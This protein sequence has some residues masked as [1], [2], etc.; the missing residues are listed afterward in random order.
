MKKL[1]LVEITVDDLQ[2]LIIDCVVTC[3]KHHQPQP[4][5]NTVIESGIKK[6][7]AKKLKADSNLKKSK[8]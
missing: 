8:I 6:P 2:T 1:I 3:L 4:I 7:L 5:P